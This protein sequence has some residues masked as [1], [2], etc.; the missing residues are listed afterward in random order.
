MYANRH[1]G[2]IAVVSAAAALAVLPVSAGAEEAPKRV[3][4]TLSDGRQ[5]RG[6]L[7]GYDAKSVRVE[8]KP[9]QVLVLPR[10]LVRSVRVIKTAPVKRGPIS[11]P[12]E[13]K[14]SSE[15]RQTPG[16]LRVPLE[17]LGGALGGAIGIGGSAVVAARIFQTQTVDAAERDDLIRLGVTAGVGALMLGPPATALGVWG[18]GKA[19]GADAAY[20]PTLGG[21]M[22]GILVGSALAIQTFDL[23]HVDRLLVVPTLMVAGGVVGYEIA[24]AARGA[25]T[26]QETRS[27]EATSG[28][29]RMRLMMLPT[30]EGVQAAMA[31][32]F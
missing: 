24:R 5:V 27:T 6:A 11:P 3:L 20:L 13:A 22:C 29:S 26:T 19:L 30:R 9:G 2:R 28:T 14:A 31:F 23:D 4:V 32:T 8:V 16:A 17:V 1:I 15:P 10:S 7:K 12:P 21:A 25:R 18:T